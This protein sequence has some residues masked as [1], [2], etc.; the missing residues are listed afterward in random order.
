[1]NPQPSRLATLAPATAW[2]G[3]DDPRTG[4]SPAFDAEVER[5][6]KPDFHPGPDFLDPLADGIDAWLHAGSEP[7]REKLEGLRHFFLGIVADRDEAAPAWRRARSWLEIRQESFAE[8]FLQRTAALAKNVEDLW[9]AIRNRPSCKPSADDLID[10]GV[11]E[12]VADLRAWSLDLRG[13]YPVT[14]GNGSQESVDSKGFVTSPSDPTA[15]VSAATIRREHC[16]DGLSLT[17]KQLVAILAKN[18]KIKQWRP[19]SNRLSVHLPDWLAYLSKATESRDRD[20]LLDDPALIEARTA[21]IRKRK[22]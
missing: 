6:K 9:A 13:K 22:S 4:L 16:P 10:L 5:A 2:H 1:M 15:Y 18:P 8:L 7:L 17:H 11:D 19:R 12:Y 20:G 21:N 14:A 3:D